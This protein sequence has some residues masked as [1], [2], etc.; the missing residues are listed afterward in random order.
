MYTV[1]FHHHDELRQQLL[2]T[3]DARIVFVNSSDWFLGSGG[4]AE[5]LSA[6]NTY[7]GK[8]WLGKSLMKLRE[9]LQ[10]LIH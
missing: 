10:V 7:H 1:Q 4:D 8:N 6:K 5:E 9:E 3:G 2:D